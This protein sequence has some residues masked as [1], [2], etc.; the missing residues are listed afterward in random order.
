MIDV[1]VVEPDRAVAELLSSA[2][3]DVIIAAP[4]IKA[5][6]L[7]Q[8]ISFIPDNISKLTCITRWLPEDI[9]SGVC[10]L[11]IFE[12]VG[13]R[14]EG[15]LRVYPHLHAKYVRTSTQVLIGSA[16]ITARALGW[17][18]PSNLELL[19]RLPINIL[20]LAEW[21]KRLLDSTLPATTELRDQLAREAEL[22]K[23]TGS[24][25]NVPEVESISQG[26][27]S[28]IL[29]FPE[30]PTPER[31]W[32]VYKGGGL[33]TMVRSAREG[34]ERDLIA[35]APPKGFSKELFEAYVTGIL[36]QMPI[37]RRIDK[38]SS[39]GLSDSQAIAFLS[40]NL[41]SDINYTHDKAW[42]VLKR[43]LTHFF[44]TEYRLETSQ[45]VLIKGKKI[46][47]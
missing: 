27:N 46:A 19:V 45:E 6:T 14:S 8:L 44:P 1:C 25:I 28:L 38:L 36:K 35:L 10:D 30:C 37:V 9:A 17:F 33:E 23:A 5:K 42:L 26:S 22:L 11:E 47:Y 3:G 15:T 39:H 18:S 32:E 43:W 13:E 2:T 20:G 7:Q 40:E 16:N 4:Y 34:A 12:V 29:W 41:D 31:L 21:E 24:A